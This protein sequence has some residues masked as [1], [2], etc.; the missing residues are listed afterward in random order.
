MHV[1]QQGQVAHP[2]LLNESPSEA[3]RR[4]LSAHRFEPLFVGDWDRAVFLHFTV[5]A[6]RLQPHVPFS[7]DLWKGQAWLSLVAFTLQDMRLN[8]GGELGRLASLPIATHPFLN[9]R[10]YVCENTEPGIHFLTEWLPNRLANLLGPTLFGLPYRHGHLTYHHE[11]DRGEA[12]QGVVETKDGALLAY[13]QRT[14]NSLRFATC[15]SE[16]ID[17]FLL[18]R[19]TAY[20]SWRGGRRGLFRVWHRPWQVSGVDIEITAHHLL[21]QVPGAADWL[22]FAKF[23]FAHFSPGAR[24]V[25]MGRPH[26]LIDENGNG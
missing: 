4:R 13:R 21:E 5:P 22:P 11:P 2:T 17:E 1:I 19:Y 7:L 24:D 8:F 20:V 23:E 15:E 26:F 10:T 3:G 9:A 12:I 18:E 14:P 6:E 16:S 25:A